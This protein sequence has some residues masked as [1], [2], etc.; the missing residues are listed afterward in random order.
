MKYLYVILFTLLT[1]YVTAQ[2]IIEWSENMIIKLEDFQ[3]SSTQIG[4]TNLNNLISG[5]KVEFHYRMSNLEFM[6][7]KNFNNKVSCEFDKN[8][9]LILAEDKS[10]AENMVAFANFEFNL[11]ELYARKIRQ[12]LYENKGAFSDT[13]FFKPIYDTLM[14]EY[15]EK[16]N[17]ASKKT[18]I[19]KNREVLAI[20]E[21]DV[22]NEI[23]LLIDFCKNCKPQ[24]KKR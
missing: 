8:I 12:K 4:N 18:E 7:T 9:A 2:N 17:D 14:K 22:K 21:E 24:K 3:S 1:N 23:T 13:N 19:G 6:M 5:I 20:L 15:Y 16:I 11:A 10:I